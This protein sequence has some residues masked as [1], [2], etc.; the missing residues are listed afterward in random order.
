[1]AK[2]IRLIEIDEQR[3]Q[4][5]APLSRGCFWE[6]WFDGQSHNQKPQANRTLDEHSIWETAVNFEILAMDHDKD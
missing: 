6:H 1:M 2:S 3:A 4:L 5:I